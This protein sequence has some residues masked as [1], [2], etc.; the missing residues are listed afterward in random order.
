MPAVTF[1]WQQVPRAVRDSENKR[2]WLG[3]GGLGT[4]LPLCTGM[5]HSGPPSIRAPN[6][7]VGASLPPPITPQHPP[8]SYLMQPER[9]VS[10]LSKASGPGGGERGS[11][12]VQFE[13]G[14]GRLPSRGSVST[15]RCRSL[16]K[17][18]VCGVQ[19]G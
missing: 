15:R 8:R 5:G 4:P 11:S 12:N 7:S 17:R 19:G 10:W 6:P 13:G 14:E 2:W 16:P 3:G 9:K 18:S 1:P